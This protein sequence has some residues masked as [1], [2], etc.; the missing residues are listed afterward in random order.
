M[1]GRKNVEDLCNIYRV[2]HK[3]RR[4]LQ[5]TLYIYIYIYIYVCVCVCVCVLQ[6]VDNEF[7]FI[8]LLHVRYIKV[9]DKYADVYCRP[10]CNVTF[11]VLYE[12]VGCLSQQPWGICRVTWSSCCAVPTVRLFVERPLHNN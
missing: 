4:D 10:M 11:I 9:F 12:T 8:G 7:F 6:L 5:I 3:S 1:C 2:I